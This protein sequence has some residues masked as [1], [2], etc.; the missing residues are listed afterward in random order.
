MKAARNAVSRLG[1]TRGGR[2][3][4]RAWG[5]RATEAGP[6]AASRSGRPT[7]GALSRGGGGR[8]TRV[9]LWLEV[10]C[11][12]AS[13]DGRRRAVLGSRVGAGCRKEEEEKERGF[14]R[15]QW[16]RRLVFFILLPKALE[17]KK[18]PLAA[19]RPS[20]ALAAAAKNRASK[21]WGMRGRGEAASTRDPPTLSRRRSNPFFLSNPQSLRLLLR[22]PT[23][24]SATA[25]R[26]PRGAG[27]TAF[28]PSPK[29]SPPRRRA[30]A[31]TR[32]A[33]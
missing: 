16:A 20:L 28:G 33:C 4:R 7:R 30:G 11:V 21:R 12:L 10:C 14:D 26:A 1:P 2:R 8:T 22:S 23:T 3:R 25:S 27:P 15:P 24:A 9:P 29:S 19:M 17:K 6:N 5:R 31:A 18:G 13:A 32:G